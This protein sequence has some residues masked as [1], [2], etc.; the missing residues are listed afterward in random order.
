MNL[1]SGNDAI[2]WL[3]AAVFVDQVG[4][5]I[6][7]VPVLLLAGAAVADGRMPLGP[8]L[9][10]AV[11]AAVLADAAWYLAGRRLGTR[12]LGTLCRVS[13]SRDGCVRQAE[14]LFARY[15]L[16]LLLVAKFLPGVAAV[17]TAMAGTLRAS[18]MRFVAV[19]A[20]GAL[21]WIGTFLLLGGLFADAVSSVL[22]TIAT[23]GTA[24]LAVVVAL[25]VAYVGMRAW[26]RWLLL[27]TLRMARIDVDEL[28]RALDGET[29]PLIVDVRSTVRQAL[30][31]RIPGALSVPTNDIDLTVLGAPDGREI[32]VYCA[33]PNEVSAARVAARLRAAG[34]TR[35]RPLAGGID[36]WRA[37]GLPVDQAQDANAPAT[38]A[39][40]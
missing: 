4:V 37:A 8:T 25:V 9:A 1:P 6:P 40:A 28:A 39:T 19:D 32:V 36:A 34:F 23:W 16:A 14:S 22:D 5:P 2:A 21:I 7:A 12:V 33:C 11:I 3:A 31:G 20:I 30:D 35:V 38:H 10:A 15:G 18:R 26:R 29:P 24:G 13:L 27:R 17:A